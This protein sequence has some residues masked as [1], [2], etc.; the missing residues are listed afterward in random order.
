[1]NQSE[2][3]PSQRRRY[4]RFDSGAGGVKGILQHHEEYQEVAEDIEDCECGEGDCGDG[5]EGV[6]LHAERVARV[7]RLWCES[8]GHWSRVP[9]RE[10]DGD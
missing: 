2:K 3:D 7:V 4:L 9:H 8:G 5:Y 6:D 10:P 1:M